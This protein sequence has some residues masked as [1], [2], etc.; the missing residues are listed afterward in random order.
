MM[1]LVLILGALLATACA[2]AIE[3]MPM[4]ERAEV[5]DK[6]LLDR[7]ESVVPMVMRREGADMW[8]LIAREYNEDPVVKTMLPATWLSARRR[9]ILVFYDNGETIERMAVA[10]YD[11]GE[12]FTKAWDPEEQPDQWA[13]LAEVVA[14][15]DPRRIAVNVSPTFALADGMSQSQF[16]GMW[17]AL[18]QTYRNRVSGGENL[19]VGWLE[20]RTDM[21]MDVYPEIMAIARSIIREG[22]SNEVIEPGVTTTVDLEWWFRERIRELRVVAWFHPSVSVQRPDRDEEFV[23]LF[24]GEGDVIQRGDL[25]HVDFGITYL[26]LNTDTQMM[27]YVL[28]ENETDIPRG[29]REAFEKG[30]RLQD[31]LTGN[32]AVGRTGNEVLAMTRETAIGEGLVPSVYTHPI[33]YHG[34][35]AGPAIGMWDKQ[36]GVPGTGDYPLYANTAYSIELNVTAAITEWGGKDVRIMLEEDAFF[37]GEGVEYIDGRQR[38]LIVIR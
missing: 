27:A 17:D 34:H 5:M 25:L 36:E 23:D 15:R 7:L 10:R 38:E 26:R 3:T 14:E 33:G 28:K 24:M 1:R 18:D 11:V 37:D 4:R 16:E 32:F 30:N 22:F 9:T 31:I 13:R 21:E 6:I 2:H 19:A 12:F 35:G 8:I 20:T 29:L